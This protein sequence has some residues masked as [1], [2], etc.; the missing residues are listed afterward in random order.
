[1]PGLKYLFLTCLCIILYTLVSENTENEPAVTYANGNVAD[2]FS[3]GELISTRPKT[4]D[5]VRSEELRIRSD[6]TYEKGAGVT[7][8]GS[9]ERV[10]APSFPVNDARFICWEIIVE[11]KPAAVDRNLNFKYSLYDADNIKI[12]DA[13]ADSW[14]PAG[15]ELTEHSACWGS[16]YPGSWKKGDYHYKIRYE[17]K[18]TGQ[19]SGL[20]RNIKFTVY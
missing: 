8:V 9:E 15:N 19:Q 7:P 20:D 16:V 3:I 2:N 14:I 1:M 10:Y 18:G 4:L 5:P 13:T 12:A 11:H 6:W 17:S